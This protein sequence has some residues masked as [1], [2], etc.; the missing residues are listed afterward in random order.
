MNIS[1]TVVVLCI[2][3]G[4]VRGAWCVVRG[5]QA[6][7]R[8]NPSECKIIHVLERWDEIT[9]AGRCSWHYSKVQRAKC[10]VPRRKKN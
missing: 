1:H 6:D 8:A 9:I 10:T 3:D 7:R 2:S 4:T 5:A